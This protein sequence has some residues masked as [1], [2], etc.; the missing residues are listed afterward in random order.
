MIQSRKI[1]DLIAEKE[2]RNETYF[3]FEFFPPKTER[4]VQNLYTRLD[5]MV[6]FG[7]LFIDVTWGAGGS[8]SELTSEIC[9]NA[10]KYSGLEPQMHITCTNMPKE[11]LD[12]ALRDIKASGMKNILALRGDP[13]RGEEWHRIE[14]GFAHARDLV[15]YIR[16]QHGDWFCIGV[17]GYPEKH[18]DCDSYQRDLEHLK[19]KV[20][21]GANLIVTQLF[22]DSQ[23]FI[24]FVKDCRAMGIS[25]PILPGIMPILNY[26]GL[27]RMCGLCGTRV[28]QKVLDDLVLIKDD[29]AAVQDYGIKQCVE[30]CKELISSGI[31][32]LHFYTLNMERSVREVLLNLL[33]I[34]ENH[35]HR[36]LPW[37]GARGGI[38]GKGKQEAVRPIYWANRPRTY[39]SR[40]EDWDNFPNGRWGDAGSPAFGT[41][42][43]Y[44]LTQLYINNVETRRKEWGS[45]KNEKDVGNSFV[46]YLKGE[47]SR[48]PWNDT[49]LASESDVISISLKNLNAAGFLTINSQPSVNGVPSTHPVHGWGGPKGYV[50]QKA[51]LE[52]FT[53][54][55]NLQKLK[56]LMPKYPSLDFQAIS[57]KGN[58]YG[59]LTGT[60]AVTWGVWASS[61]IKQPTVVDPQVFCNIWKDEAF[62]LW[63]SQWV[64]CYEEG[65]ES[66]NVLKNIADTYYLVTVV[67]NNF[68]NGNIFAIFEEIIGSSQ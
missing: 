44:H 1:C 7:P 17:A 26:N 59:T 38:N 33:L 15:A 24:K 49:S 57:A 46:A 45:P 65:S 23:V 43:D 41:L 6:K 67:E 4:G 25:V 62:A 5:R 21:A 60:A 16:Q 20:D 48:L 58:H 11:K 18:V 28:P 42:G 61:E 9:I 53:S 2:A 3:S 37:S 19:L 29:D 14:G 12:K 50:Y 56:D 54:P 13:P 39:I 10:Y 68:I 8:T 52:F 51:Y 36:D 35:L 31:R 66:Y 27:I 30:M 64:S 47:I 34:S 63:H 55:E 32:G 22:Y 40:S